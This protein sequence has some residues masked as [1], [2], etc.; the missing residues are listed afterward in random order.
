MKGE[1]GLGGLAPMVYAGFGGGIIVVDIIFQVIFRN[2]KNTF[3]V[4]EV[5]LLLAFVIWMYSIGGI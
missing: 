2:Y 5:I 3:F 4:I 1:P